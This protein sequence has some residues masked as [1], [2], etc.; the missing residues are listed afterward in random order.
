M[1]DSNC[2]TISS[3][4]ICLQSIWVVVISCWEL[5]GCATWVQSPWTLRNYPYFLL[6]SLIH[7]L[8]RIQLG[9]SKIII[10]HCMENFLKKGYFGII[11][12]FNSMQ[13]LD[14]FAPKIHFNSQMDLNKHHQVFETPKGL[15]PTQGGHDHGVPLILG[16]Q[17]LST[18]F[19]TK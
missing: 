6:K 11:S 10:S 16:S 2:V 8:K 13:V 3:K 7:T 14:I 5:N 17:S 19:C 4:H 1:C 12:H 9:S 18:P 15:P